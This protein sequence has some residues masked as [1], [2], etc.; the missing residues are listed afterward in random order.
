MHATFAALMAA[1]TLAGSAAAKSYYTE[2]LEDPKA[3]YLTP[4]RFPVRADGVADDS[5]ALQQ[6]IDRVEET[7]R[8]GIVFIPEGVYRLGRTVCVWPGVRLIGYGARRP[9]L[10]LGANTPGFQD[11]AGKYMLYFAGG[12]PRAAG[13]PVRDGNPGTFYSAASNIDIEIRDGN[14]AAVA[15]RFHVAQHCYL[16]HMD[17]RIGSARAA[18][19]DIGNEGEDLHF[20]G[21]EYGIVTT[22]TAPSWPYLLID[23]TFEGQR[24]AAI[25]SREA[26][27]TLVR[28]RFKS[29]PAAVAID[30]GYAEELWLKDCLFDNIAG[31][32]IVFG[33]E[34]NPRTQINAEDVVCRRV[35]VFAAMRETGKRVAGPAQMYTVTRFS[36]GL[37]LDGGGAG[38]IDTRF[39]ARPIS[40]MPAMAPSDIPGLPP[41]ADWV[42]VRALGAAGDGSTDDTAAL[43]SAI[44]AHRRCIYRWGAIA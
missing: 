40:E 42:N 37:H 3:V 27:L 26:G 19:E 28:N 18:L 8:T 10:L 32:A 16:A 2:R 23:S 11:G 13:Q 4:D 35:H 1:L 36:H 29:V 15:V 41:G 34:N 31:P 5:A 9:V 30:E 38:Q 22:K 44:A 43:K 20:F 24:A 12:R 17:F 21:G 7:T 14:P 39:D 33:N 6:A 25:K